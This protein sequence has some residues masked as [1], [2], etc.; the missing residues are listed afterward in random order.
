[1]G[2]DDSGRLTTAFYSATLIDRVTGRAVPGCN[3]NTSGVFGSFT[4]IL[5]DLGSA[6]LT[7]PRKIASRSCPE[8]DC[9]PIPRR[10]ELALFRSDRR[11]EPAFVGPIARVFEDPGADTLTITAADRLFWAQGAQTSRR[12]GPGLYPGGATS[13]ISPVVVWDAML[14]EAIKY[15]G[16]RMGLVIGESP[17]DLGGIAIE[18]PILEVGESVW[19]VM[20]GLAE[21]TIDFAVVGPHLYYGAP[22]IGIVDGPPMETSTHWNAD[23]GVAVDIDGTATVSQVRVQGQNGIV[24]YWPQNTT[25]H[26]SGDTDLGFGNATAFVA[27]T[28]VTTH[29]EALALARFTYE[30]NVTPAQFLVTAGGSLSSQA[31]VSM[32]DLIPGRKFSVAKTDGCAV[33]E[34]LRRLT[35]SIT[36]FSAA[37]HRGG[38][39]LAETGVQVDLQPPGTQ[40]SSTRVSAA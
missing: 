2:C 10:H 34:E 5:D 6:D 35:S 4:R 31:P 1:M 23:T 15:N 22:E 17:R 19:A 25:G 40:G 32:H 9:M 3:L 16:G 39:V 37:S 18:P 26:G 11:S 21:S 13:E 14:A 8:C 33:G 29:A 36:S 30:R 12:Y 38:V 28:D 24:A 27:S 7:I 20:T